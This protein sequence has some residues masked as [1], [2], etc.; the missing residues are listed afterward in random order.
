MSL[1]FKLNS[2]YQN[3]FKILTHY[4]QIQVIA[5]DDLAVNWMKTFYILPGR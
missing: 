1:Q 3:I 5:E 2:S 4:T